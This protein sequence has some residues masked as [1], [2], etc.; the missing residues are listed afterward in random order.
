LRRSR[1]FTLIE[2]MIALMI[3]SITLVALSSGQAVALTSTRKS[4]LVTMATIAAKNKMAEIDLMADVK[5]FNYVKDLGEKTEDPFDEE[6]YKGWK[7]MR[8]VKE[9]NIPITAIMKMFTSQAAAEGEAE[10][11]AGTEAGT[12]AAPLGGGEEAQI[13]DMITSNIEKLM[14]NSIR[15]I[16][17]TVYWPV[18]AGKEFSSIK[19]VYYVVDFETVQTFTPVM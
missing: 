6:V 5:G 12:G 11:E 1:A 8:E 18:K 7:W 14:K 4:R 16:T 15:E 17:V 10:G 19:L 2:V 3:L 13:L 9:V